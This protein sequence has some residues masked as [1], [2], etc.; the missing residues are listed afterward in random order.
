MPFVSPASTEGGT[1][2]FVENA[3]AAR[4][5]RLLERSWEGLVASCC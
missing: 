5:Y 1:V 2:C 3:L 4:S